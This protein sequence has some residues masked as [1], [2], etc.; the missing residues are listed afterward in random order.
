VCGPYFFV[1][2]DMGYAS[3]LEAKTGKSLWQEKLGRHHWPSPVRAGNLL[4]F[5]DDDSNTHVVKAAPKF[6]LVATNPLG[7]EKESCYA[8]PA[9]S[10]G[11]IFI[12]TL[13]NLYC[14]GK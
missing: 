8:S 2:S 6:E 9:I 1:V 4:Y 7:E 10:R 11:Q 5:L 13:G 3:C 12:R 14:I